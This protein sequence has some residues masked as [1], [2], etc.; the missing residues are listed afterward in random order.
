MSWHKQQRRSAAHHDEAVQELEGILKGI[1]RSEQIVVSLRDEMEDVNRKYPAE[2][3][4]QE[5]VDF[6]TDLLAC[7]RKKLL[8][9]KQIEVLKRRVPAALE[10]VSKTVTDQKA[11]PTPEMQSDLLGKLKTVQQAMERLDSAVR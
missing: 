4:T 3:T 7:A 1:E 2:R 6:L 9:E 5:D 11:P 8:L 10:R